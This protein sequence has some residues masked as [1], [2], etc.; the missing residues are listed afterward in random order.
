MYQQEFSSEEAWTAGT[1]KY[2]GWHFLFHLTNYCPAWVHEI[3]Q[4]KA[5]Q[6]VFSEAA[7]IS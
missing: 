3:G 4:S 5:H 1:D 7:E 6:E 2:S